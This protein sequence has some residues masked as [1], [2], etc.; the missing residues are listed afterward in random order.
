MQLK[1]QMAELATYRLE[2]AENQR[3]RILALLH[4]LMVQAGLAKDPLLAYAVLSSVARAGLIFSINEAA[5][6][7]TASPGPALM[8]CLFAVATI[9]FAHLTRI[10]SHTMVKGLQRDMRLALSRGVLSADARFL[11]KRDKGPVYAAITNEI[12]VISGVAINLVQVTQAVFLLAFCIP[13]LFWVSWFTGLTTL[14]AVGFGIIGYV[15]A[16]IPARALVA[17]ANR[18]NAVFFNRVNDI[19]SGWVEI[20]LSNRRRRDI[21]KDITTTADLIEQM[22]VRAE[23]YF[24]I[25]QGFSEAALIL[26]IS[27]NIIFL[28]VISGSPT[29]VF[30]VL[31]VVLLTYGPIEQIFAALPQMSRAIAAQRRISDV[32]SDFQDASQPACQTEV[33]LTPQQIETIEFRNVSVAI[34]DDRSDNNDRKDRFQ[35]GPVNLVLRAGEVVFI[36]GGNGAGKSTFLTLLCGLRL[37]DSGEILLN[38]APLRPETMES[39]R[40]LFSAVLSQFH[41]FEKTYGFDA[42]N[43]QALGENVEKL[44]IADRV[45]WRDGAF[46]S[47]ALSTG[48]RR[49]LALAVALSEKRQVL[50]LDEFSADQD[51]TNRAYFYA[52]L[53]PEMAKKHDLLIAVTH[54]EQNF[55]RCNHLVKL[56]AGRIVV[57]QL[58]GALEKGDQYRRKQ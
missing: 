25:S 24:S 47:L 22:D 19:L 46:N 38:G 5:R 3:Q 53:I 45:L 52:E 42:D 58:T 32:V 29:A 57:D 4:F 7:L 17:Q 49:R 6:V 14:A 26:L 20:R 34:D 43:L 51:P 35:F 40:A 13:Y 2:A 56:D 31:T 23:R 54:D 11:L 10:R 12:T 16:D 28:P 39:Y 21:D 18:A 1:P 30:Q 44:H 50:V 37:P 27:A 9:L 15:I 36:T 48:Q 8:L 41:L 55:S 33:N